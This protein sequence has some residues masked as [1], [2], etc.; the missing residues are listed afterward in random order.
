MRFCDLLVLLFFIVSLSTI[1]GALARSPENPSNK[2]LDF[3]S[4]PA[5]T[6]WVGR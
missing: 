6:S 3:E 2:Q 5:G 1:V 4:I